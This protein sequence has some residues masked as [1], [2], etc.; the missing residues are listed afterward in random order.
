MASGVAMNLWSAWRFK[1]KQTTRDPRGKANSLAQDGLYRLSRNPMY[2][3]MLILLLGVN[4]YLGSLIL[5][6]APLVFM[7][8]VTERFIK[9]E[10]RILLA[11][12][13]DAYIQYKSRVRRWI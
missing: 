10:E 4:I 5:F 7:R 9:R 12:F 3:G 2:L 11:C 8:I 1:T 13:G 6:P